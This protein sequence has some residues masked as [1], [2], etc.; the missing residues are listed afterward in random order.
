M[1]NKTLERQ[2]VDTIL[3]EDFNKFN[4]LLEDSFYINFTFEDGHDGR[5]SFLHHCK[6]VEMAKKLVEK[7]VNPHQLDSNGLTPIFYA[8]NLELIQFYLDLKV[9]YTLMNQYEQNILFF[10]HSDNGY[11]KAK[12]FLNLGINPNQ[13]DNE[14]HTLL[15][16]NNDVRLVELYTGLGLDVNATNDYGDSVLQTINKYGVIKFLLE[17]GAKAEQVNSRSSQNALFTAS[18][19]LQK[20]KLLIKYGANPHLINYKGQNLL[21]TPSYY[22]DQKIVNFL[23]ELGVNSHLVSEEGLTPREKAKT[24]GFNT[25]EIYDI[26]NE[27]KELNNLLYNAHDIQK[28]SIT[29]KNK[30]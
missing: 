13:K 14:S 22:E 6:N 2:L 27:Q 23:M 10:V 9:D 11:E 17:H 28:K 20:I 30:I 25:F 21:H 12:T 3:K 18:P 7:G 4:L 5:K 16:Y 26:L 15:H 24:K 1:K 29:K 8:Y 19:T